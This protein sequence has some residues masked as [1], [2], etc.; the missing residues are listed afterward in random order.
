LQAYYDAIMIGHN[1]YTVNTVDGTW[2]VEY[3]TLMMVYA[4]EKAVADAS[5]INI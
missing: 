4:L 5:N 2:F 3:M 1:R